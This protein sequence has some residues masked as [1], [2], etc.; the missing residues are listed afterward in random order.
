MYWVL[1]YLLVV[2]TLFVLLPMSL[3]YIPTLVM[4]DSFSTLL[5]ERAKTIPL[6]CYQFYSTS[7]P[8]M[9]KEDDGYVVPYF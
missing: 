8:F 6:G 2:V 7:R 3:R 1:T 4:L 9:V 5:V